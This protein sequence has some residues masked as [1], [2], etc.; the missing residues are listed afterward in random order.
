MRK[1]FFNVAGPC[2][3]S[4]HYMLDPFRDIGDELIKKIRSYIKELGLPEGFAK[5]ADYDDIAEVLKSSFVDYC[6][7]LDKTLVV[8]FDE[9]DCLANGTLISFLRQYGKKIVV[10][11]C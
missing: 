5:D 6:R 9:A 7:S 4:E 3:P 11:G 10:A 1:R 2:V 8:F